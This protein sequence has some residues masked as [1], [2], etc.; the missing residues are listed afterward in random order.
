MLRCKE[1]ILS[2][3]IMSVAAAEQSRGDRVAPAPSARRGTGTTM[4]EGSQMFLEGLDPSLETFMLPG[5]CGRRGRR[6]RSASRHIDPLLVDSDEHDAGAINA[7][8][9]KR[10]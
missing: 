10:L 7:M 8:S 3:L 6:Q 2:I 1:A 4:P 9:R 5:L